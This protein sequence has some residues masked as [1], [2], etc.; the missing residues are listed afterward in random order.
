MDGCL[1]VDKGQVA[2]R[3]LLITELSTPLTSVEDKVAQESTTTFLHVDTGVAA[4][5]CLGQLK[6]DV[7]YGGRLRRWPVNSPGRVRNRGGVND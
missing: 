2:S 4:V 6:D 3:V 5:G 7:L 1:A